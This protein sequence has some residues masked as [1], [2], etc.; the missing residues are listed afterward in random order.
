MVLIAS[1]LFN[2]MTVIY[3]CENLSGMCYW[4]KLTKF[5]VAI[6]HEYLFSHSG[7]VVKCIS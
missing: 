5:S 6:L 4:M 2:N 1:R 3:S 7:I